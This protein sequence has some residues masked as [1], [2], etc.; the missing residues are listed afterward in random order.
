VTARGVL[1]GLIAATLGLAAA[2]APAGGDENIAAADIRI[3]L[4]P[5]AAPSVTVRPGL[6]R[7]VIDLP[8]GAELPDDFAAASGG[9]VRRGEVIPGPADRLAV[10][11]ELAFGFLD[12]VVYEPDAVVLHFES[13]YQSTIDGA[14]VESPYLIGPDDKLRVTVHNQTDLTGPL[15]V[16]RDGLITAPL[17][18]DVQAAGLTPRQL[19][20][21]LAERF[22]RSYLVDPRVDVEV[23]E[24][25]SQWVIVGGEVRLPG[26][27]PLRGGTRLKEVIGEAQGLGPDSGETIIISREL[28]SGETVS[29][30]ID[31]AD[32]ES[33]RRNP[34]LSH[35]DI[36][37]VPQADSCYIQGEV[38]RPGQV[39]IER[40]MTLLRV[41]AHAEGLTEWADRKSVTVLYRDGSRPPRTYNLARIVRGKEPD[42][43]MRGGEMIIVRKRFL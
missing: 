41:I 2:A 5:G 27:V 39:L 13:R 42:P 19:A 36:I 30:H 25:R 33:G 16:S 43:V 8:R 29:L 18:G 9:L 10:E 34:Q 38:R 32:F 20:A 3:A 7:V 26:R 28:P 4:P 40:G 22:G 37:E 24:Y 1:C 21:R 11:L 23:E 35:G 15:V 12:H 31:R 17:I 6:D 14:A